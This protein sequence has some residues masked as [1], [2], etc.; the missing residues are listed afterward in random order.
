M[1]ISPLVF[2]FAFRIQS[3]ENIGAFEKYRFIYLRNYRSIR[4]A[5]SMDNFSVFHVPVG[6][7]LL[8]FFPMSLPMLFV[9]SNY[10]FVQCVYLYLFNYVYVFQ[11]GFQS[12]TRL[13]LFGQIRISA[14]EEYR[15][16]K[17]NYFFFL[18]SNLLPN[19]SNYK[20]YFNWQIR[21]VF[22]DP[23]HDVN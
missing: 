4:C 2:F 11:K 9:Y 13:I 18:L 22:R 12:K 1:Q 16:T 6:N 21:C 7:L 14:V 10:I 5:V 20:L 15:A 19:P 23:A 3:S 8:F 17:H